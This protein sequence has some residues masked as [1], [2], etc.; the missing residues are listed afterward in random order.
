MLTSC[1][2]GQNKFQESFTVYINYPDHTIKAT[3]VSDLKKVKTNDTLTYYWYASNKIL[4]TQGGFDGK[5]LNGPFTSFYLSSALKEKGGFKNGL[6]N[7]TWYF[8]FENGKA[9]RISNWKSGVLN[10]KTLEY[11]DKGILR[12]EYNFKN[13]LWH[14]DYIEY[15]KDTIF[16]KKKFKNG[17]EIQP[18]SKKVKTKKTSNNSTV[19]SDV[20]ED[21]KPIV[22]KKNQLFKSKATKTDSSKN[23]KTGTKKIK[24]QKDS[25]TSDSNDK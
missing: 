3:V 16:V 9:K 25:Q 18:K 13:G 5:L 17:K 21:S 12:F 11:D 2:Y 20:S 10:G 8:W 19:N 24:P 14:G 4:K 6:K 7:G 22:K 23:A 1:L 15:S